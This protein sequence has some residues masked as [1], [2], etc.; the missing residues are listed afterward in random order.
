M[1]SRRQKPW[2]VEIQAPSDGFRAS[3][4]CHVELT[5]EPLLGRKTNVE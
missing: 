4:D 5:M 3:H 2:M 1:S